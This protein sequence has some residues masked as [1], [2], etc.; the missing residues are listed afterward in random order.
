VLNSEHQDAAL[1]GNDEWR[2]RQVE[3]AFES[4]LHR[5]NLTEGQIDSQDRG[6]LR[7]SLKLLNEAIV[8]AESFGK[9]KIIVAPSARARSESP[10]ASGTTVEFGAMPTLLR[11]RQY[12]EHKLQEQRGLRF[13]ADRFSGIGKQLG[14][15]GIAVFGILFVAY[16]QFYSALGVTPEDVGVNYVY[17]LA[18]SIGLMLIAALLLAYVGY[19]V[20]LM[21]T[22]QKREMLN[23][24]ERRSVIMTKKERVRSAV[25]GCVSIAAGVVFYIWLP[26]D[27][28]ERAASI[29]AVVAVIATGTLSV[30]VALKG[31]RAER[32]TFLGVGLMSLFLAFS[33]ALATYARDLGKEALAGSVVE[34]VDLVG[35]PILDI[36]AR[37]VAV[38]WV[39]PAAQ[40]PTNLFFGGQEVCA[41]DLGRSSTTQ[42]LLAGPTEVPANWTLVR[43]PIATVVTRSLASLQ[44]CP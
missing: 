1:D 25:V 31:R 16:H 10:D 43:L 38:Q 42:F 27:P 33:V 12:V 11:R 2:E 22:L 41:I 7:D 26:D 5:L 30:A 24:R 44:A 21:S 6:G 4:Q 9:V 17:V 20:L 28:F 14:I 39:G 8:Q 40:R 3:G 15:L 34:P 19:Q 36:E 23:K 29:F 18:R 35:V 37:A 13:P 32:L